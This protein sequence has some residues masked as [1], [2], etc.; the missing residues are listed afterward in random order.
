CTLYL[1]ATV[2]QEKKSLELEDSDIEEELEDSDIE[3]E[4][5]DSDIEEELEDSDIEEELE[6][7]D[8]E[9]EL[10]TLYQELIME[11]DAFAKLK[12]S[13]IEDST[14]PTIKYYRGSQQSRQTIWRDKKRKLDLQRAATSTA[15]ITEYFKTRNSNTSEVPSDLPAIKE[16]RKI[17]DIFKVDSVLFHKLESKSKKS[18]SERTARNWLNKLG[19]EFKDVRKGVYIDGH[20]REDVVRYRQEV[21]LPAMEKLF[22]SGLREWA[23][24]GSLILKEIP[25]GEKEKILVTH[26]E[27]T[28]NA[29]DGKRRMWIQNDA[30]PLRQKSKG[31]GIMISEVLT[32]RV[33]HILEVA[34]PIFERAFPE[35]QAVFLFDNT[36]NHNTYASDAL[37]VSNIN[38]VSGGKQAI[39]RDGF[40]YSKGMPQ[41]MVFPDDYSDLLLRGKA[42]DIRQVLM[43]RDLW[44][45]SMKLNSQRGSLQEGIEARGHLVLFYPKFHCEL[46]FIEFFWA[47]AKRHAR[48]NCEY[49][50][51]GLR[52]TIP[53]S[54]NSVSELTIWR[55]YNKCQRTM[56]AYRD[57][58][59]YGTAEFKERVYK[60][61]RHKLA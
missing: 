35:K 53:L 40:I 4:L 15:L 3:E 50:L 61:H 10:E 42:K 56:S 33:C 16:L 47:A 17:M 45:P 9:E 55:F 26:D 30:Q 24:D 58:C 31:R 28:F 11:A 12:A 43:E 13:V 20:E 22:H 41:S 51:Q 1:D 38:L 48:E 44:L 5:E 59:Q 7:S 36:S 46:N 39:L 23:E 37:L 32:P 8:I 34:I 19:F 57:G 25:A 27:S 18:I 6:D 14:V 49:S 29:N 54:L 60:S 21:F 2:D 52:D